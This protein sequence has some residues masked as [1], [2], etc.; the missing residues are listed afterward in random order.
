MIDAI[1]TEKALSLRCNHCGA[2]LEIQNR[3]LELIRCSSCGT[4]QKLVDAHAFLEQIMGQVY[5]WVKT[6]LPTGFELSGTEKVDPVARYTI[7]TTHVKPSIELEYSHLFFNSQKVMAQPLLSL[8]FKTST[9]I[10]S[11]DDPVKVFEFNAK[12]NSIKPL[13]FDKEDSV[14]I[15]DMDSLSLCFAYILNNIRLF[16]KDTPEK[17]ELMASNYFIASESIKNSE[18]FKS[19]HLR[20]SGLS[21]ISLSVHFLM[22]RNCFEAKRIIDEGIVLLEEGNKTL[23]IERNLALMGQAILKELTVAKVIKK[24]ILASD[25]DP[26]GDPL[27]TLAIIEKLMTELQTHEKYDSGYW[28]GTFK[29]T[30]R[31]HQIF[32]MFEKIRRSQN[33]RGKIRFHPGKGSYLIPFWVIDLP[34]SF[35]T[36]FFL[37]KKGCESRDTIFVSST[38]PTDP[39]SL[40]SRPFCVLTDVFSKDT[41]TVFLGGI[42]SGL[43][44]TEKSISCGNNIL[45]EIAR[46]TSLKIVGNKKIIPPLT[47]KK[48]VEKMV[49]FY[50]HS[51]LEKNPDINRKFGLS[52]PKITGLIFIPGELQ[53]NEFRLNLDIGDLKP[54][55]I[56]DVSKL[57]YLAM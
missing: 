40:N 39:D 11:Q 3:E 57:Q 51:M 25:E 52:A 53:G 16:T 17:Y 13:I 24:M 31:Y 26:S 29:D 7:F 41:N 33:G 22:N 23:G 12:I 28:K 43:F 56:G 45:Q 27:N 1:Q 5:A 48:Q 50:I 20:F 38:F 34:Y 55:S 36:G 2:P 8:P 18:K 37:N 49:H 35:K 10:L 4:T 19:L 15:K 42:L 32:T 14:C 30:E 44:A 47:S 54:R 9:D 21:K 46:S 6:S